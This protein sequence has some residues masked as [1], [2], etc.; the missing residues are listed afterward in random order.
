MFIWGKLRVCFFFNFSTY[1]KIPNAGKYS[2]HSSSAFLMFWIMQR[3]TISFIMRD[4][5][6][7]QLTTNCLICKFG[8][9]I[10]KQTQLIKTL[11]H[12]NNIFNINTGPSHTSVHTGHHKLILAAALTPRFSFFAVTCV[13]ATLENTEVWIWIWVYV[14]QMYRSSDPI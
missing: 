6:I 14:S 2:R 5:K 9:F 8:A 10:W 13:T 7:Q 3:E 4:V 1:P 12:C 11:F